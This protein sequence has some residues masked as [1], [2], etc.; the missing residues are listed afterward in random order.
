[1]L[2]GLA[3]ADSC[4]VNLN[5]MNLQHIS[6]HIGTTTYNYGA[7]TTFRL[8]YEE[9]AGEYRVLLHFDRLSDSMSGTPTSGGVR[10]YCSTAAGTA[11][12]IYVYRTADNKYIREGI[13]TGGNSDCSTNWTRYEEGAGGDPICTDRAWTAAGGDFGATKLDSF[14]LPTSTGW[15]TWTFSDS[16]IAWFDKII[17]GSVVIDSVTGGGQRL[18]DQ[19]LLLKW[20]GSGTETYAIFSSDNASSNQAEAWFVGA[21]LT[22]LNPPVTMYQAVHRKGWSV[23]SHKDGA[24]SE[25]THKKG[26]P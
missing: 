10:W 5:N 25:I 8:G 14:N 16:L 19:V 12:K 21:G 17:D 15:F 6:S 7:A 2:A 4:A 23:I 13:A 20:T 24:I 9:F 1:M 3:R 18:A 26:L 11:I 22:D